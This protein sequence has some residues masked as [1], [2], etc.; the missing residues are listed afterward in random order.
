MHSNF[1]GHDGYVALLSVLLVSAIAAM[2]VLMLLVTSLNTTLNSGDVGEGRAARAMADAC[3]EK[4]LLLLRSETIG[5]NYSCAD[6]CGISWTMANQGTCF[7]KAIKD[8]GAPPD[9][10]LFRIRAT[11]AGPSS[12]PITKYVETEA[13]RKP[14]VAGNPPQAFAPE[15]IRWE[16]CR[17]FLKSIDGTPKLITEDCDTNSISN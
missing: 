9:G 12:D 11:G 13:Y 14:Q 2:T 7:V 6:N 1:R 8:I 3:M 10:T 5:A 16:E 17:D 4:A 15:A